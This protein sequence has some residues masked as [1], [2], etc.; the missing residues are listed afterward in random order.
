MDKK[1]LYISPAL[2]FVAASFDRNFLVS[3]DYPGST[4][5]DVTEEE[6]TF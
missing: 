2:R 1:S 3:T 4:I 5:E 6:W